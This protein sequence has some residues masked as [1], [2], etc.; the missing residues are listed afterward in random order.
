MPDPKAAPYIGPKGVIAKAMGKTIGA[1]FFKALPTPFSALFTPF[2]T[3][4]T[5]FF[6]PLNKPFR[7]NSGNPVSGFNLF[8]LVPTSYLFHIF[9][10]T[11]A[12]FAYA[13]IRE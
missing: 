2:A 7:K 12:I 5:A 8:L 10:F 6:T 13:T 1:T 3:P 4:L 11:S 9:T